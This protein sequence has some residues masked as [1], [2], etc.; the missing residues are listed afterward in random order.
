MNIVLMKCGCFFGC[1]LNCQ[2]VAWEPRTNT[3]HQRPTA[4]VRFGPPACR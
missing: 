1:R 2:G 4:N 3:H